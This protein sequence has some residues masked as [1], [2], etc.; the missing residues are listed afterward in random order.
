MARHGFGRG[1]YQYF[2]NPLPEIVAD[3]QAL[4]YREVV[5]VRKL[6]EARS[7]A[8]MRATRPHTPNF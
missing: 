6:L 3:F 8:P 1:E 5:H 2:A 4:L 7:W